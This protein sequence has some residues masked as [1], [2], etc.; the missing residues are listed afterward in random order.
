M[1]YKAGDHC[2]VLLA[3]T[4]Y[5]GNRPITITVHQTECYAGRPKLIGINLRK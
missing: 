3:L 5:L 2:R 4:A 1:H